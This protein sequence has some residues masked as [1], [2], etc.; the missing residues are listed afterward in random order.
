MIQT[1]IY[2]IYLCLLYIPVLVR[3]AEAEV[4]KYLKGWGHKQNLLGILERRILEEN[5]WA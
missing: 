3:I 2:M 4:I 5:V 1:T